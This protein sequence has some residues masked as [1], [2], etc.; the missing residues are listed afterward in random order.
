[1]KA[2]PLLLLGVLVSVPGRV[3]GQA[4]ELS[5]QQLN[6]RAFTPIDEAPTDISALAQTSDGTLWIG[7]RTGLTRFDGMRF[8]GY[9]GDA[10]EPLPGTN[11]ASLFA[12]PDGGLWIGFR[13]GGAAVLEGGRVTR[14]GESEGLPDGT[15][16]QFARD[17]D[18][19]AVGRHSSWPGEIQR[20]A[21]G[22]IRRP[23]DRDALRL[24]SGSRRHVVGRCEQ[25]TVRLGRRRA[26]VQGNRPIADLRRGWHR[27]RAGAR[28]QHLGGATPQAGARSS[29]PRRRDC[30]ALPG[31]PASP[32]VRCCSM[33]PGISGLRKAPPRVCCACSPAISRMRSCRRGLCSPSSFRAPSCRTLARVFATLLDRERN[34]WV[35][36]DN[37]LHRFSR[38]NV[39]RGVVPRCFQYGFTAAGFAP[40]ADGALWIRLRRSFRRARRRNS[41]RQGGEQPGLGAV[42]RRVSRLRRNRV[43]CRS[44]CAGTSGTAAGSS[45]C[46]CPRKCRGVPLRRWCVSAAGRC[47]FPSRAA[48]CFASTTASGPRTAASTTLPRGWR[49]VAT[50]DDDGALWFGY[51]NNRIARVEGRDVRVFDAAQGLDVGNVLAILAEDGELWVGGELGLARFEGTRFVIAAKR[52]RGAVQRSLGHRARAQWRS[53]AE[54]NRRHRAHRRR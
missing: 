9:P 45:A 33:G 27:A 46:R 26:A 53:L 23:E 49:I 54:R 19:I 18:G 50:M 16:E 38:S 32:A 2:I 20:I 8:V 10:E 11:I 47:G 22:K 17:R 6:H 28:W 4:A 13:P 29:D 40:G 34:V 15:V 12:E 30:R 31:C 21:L 42:H 14:F 52:F 48:A 1:M 41:R 5:L 39:V 36:T 51:T 25:R 43:V 37:G 35:G 24:V 3:C 7:G 44:Y